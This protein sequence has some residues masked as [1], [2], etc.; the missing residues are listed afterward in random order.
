MPLIGG[1]CRM[2]RFFTEQPNPLDLVVGECKEYA[3]RDIAAVDAHLADLRERINLAP[4]L[5]KL[6]KQY[7]ADLDKLLDRRL[8]LEMTR[9][10]ELT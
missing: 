8:W 4:Q 10:P 1:V 9:T 7:R 2:S 5:P 6:L 3:C